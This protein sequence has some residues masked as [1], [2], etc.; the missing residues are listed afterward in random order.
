VWCT[1]TQSLALSRSDAAQD[2]GVTLTDLESEK[3]EAVQRED[4]SS[5]HELKKQV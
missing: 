2:V 4:Y 1:H 5:A 3:L